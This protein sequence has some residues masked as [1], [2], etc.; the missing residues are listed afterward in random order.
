MNNGYVYDSNTN[1]WTAIANMPQAREKPGVAADNGKL[2]V[3]G[4]WDSNGTP[5]AETDV[6]DPSTD[7]WSSAA[8]YPH[9]DAWLACGGINGKVYCSG[10]TNGSSTYSDAFVY[11]PGS[12]T[13]TAI[14]SMPIDLWASAS[15]APNGLFVVSSG[16]TNGFSTITNQGFAYDPTT[17]TW[18]SIPNAQFPRYRMGGSCGFYKIG[19]SSGG[20][21]PTA[22]SEVLSGMTQCGTVDIPWMSENPATATIAPG[23]SVNVTVTLTATP[24]DQVT[25]PGTYTAQIGFEQDTPYAV[26]AENVTMNVTPPKSWGK[27]AGTVTGLDCSNK[28]VPIKGAVFVSSKGGL[29]L[30]LKTDNN[31]NY[32]VWADKSNSPLTL[33]ATASGWIAQT[34]SVKFKAGVTTTVNFTLRPQSC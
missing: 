23:Q 32:A 1:G 7:S 29:S 30:T 12:D 15:G 18:T 14:A 2:Y 17:N 26:P 8:P 28:T 5:I 31:G 25:Q 13:W 4:G 22:D 6:Y 33:I 21:S 10:G 24:A 16:V 3:S 34:K 20:F 19:G 9:G 11:D 27:V